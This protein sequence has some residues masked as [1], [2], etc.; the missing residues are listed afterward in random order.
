MMVGATIRTRTERRATKC[1]GAGA[2]GISRCPLGCRLDMTEPKKGLC[3][4]SPKPS[5]P[6]ARAHRH[7][8]GFDKSRKNQLL[9]PKTSL[10]SL[11]QEKLTQNLGNSPYSHACAGDYTL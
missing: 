10:E 7:R 2:A 5:R 9:E 11:F 1:E 4:A 8:F 3:E 6:E